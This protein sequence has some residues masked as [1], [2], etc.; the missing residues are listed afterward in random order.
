MKMDMKHGILAAALVTAGLCMAACG[1][2]SVEDEPGIVTVSNAYVY[3]PK[4]IS[5]NVDV[6]IDSLSVEGS[7]LYYFETQSWRGER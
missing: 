2:K 1:K 3:T 7:R 5:L 6:Q 4:Q